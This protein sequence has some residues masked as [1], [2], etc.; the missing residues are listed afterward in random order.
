VA[1][2]S[3]RPCTNFTPDSLAPIAED[4]LLCINCFYH[5]SAHWYRTCQE[6]GNRQHDTE[7]KFGLTDVYC[8]R[9]CKK[10]K[11]PALDYGTLPPLPEA[12]DDNVTTH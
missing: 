11:S 10:C 1:T 2:R 6:C 8:N 3:N 9:K 12:E 5:H 7:P 4:R